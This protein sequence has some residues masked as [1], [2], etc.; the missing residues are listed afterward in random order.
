M[1]KLY[2]V[3]PAYNEAENLEMLMNDWYP[4]IENSMNRDSRLVVVNDGS[5]DNTYD[6]LCMMA[7]E[8]PML[9]V[10]DKKK[11]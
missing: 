5:N 9:K 2:I 8:W 10:L 6:I 3:I 1:D 7:K 11:G 4:V